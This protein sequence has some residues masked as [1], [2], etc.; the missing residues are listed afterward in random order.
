MKKRYS[1]ALFIFFLLLVAGCAKQAATGPTGKAF[2]G[3]TQGLAISFLSNQPPAEVFDVDF[4]FQIGLKLENKGEFDINDPNTVKLSINGI[5]PADFKVN[6]GDLQKSSP[7]LLKGKRI[8]SQGQ[9]IAGD[10]VTVDFPQMQYATTVNGRIPFTIRANVCYEYGTKAQGSLCV[11]KDLR[12]T[13][14]EAAI[15]NPDRTVPAENSGAPVQ[16]TAFRQNVA[17][18]NK[19]DFFFTITKSGPQADSLFKTGSS[20]DTALPNRD[21]VYVD[22]ADTGLGDLQCFGLNGGTSSRS[23]YATLFNGQREI[24][25][26]Q[27]ITNPVDAEKV[28]SVS[29]TYA[30]K[31]YVDTQLFVKHAS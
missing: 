10:I 11:R 9:V 25:C 23:G 24:H 18:T 17:G 26:S 15:C 31:Q 14:G 29:L 6:S 16:I 2:V 20:C 13:T 12:G 3:G 7:E 28:I 8:D 21:V 27:T 5:V 19:I 1:H 30:Y 4:P 22:V